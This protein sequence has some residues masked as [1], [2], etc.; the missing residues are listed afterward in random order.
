MDSLAPADSLAVF[1]IL[2]DVRAAE[3][4]DELD[5]ETVRFLTGNSPAGRIADLLDR[6]PMDD[7]AEVVSEADPRTAHKLLENLEARAPADAEEVRRLLAYPRGSAGRLMT[8]RFAAVSPSTTADQVLGYLR[9]QADSLETVNDIYVLDDQKFLRGVSAIRGVLT[10][11]PDQPISEFMITAPVSVT[12]EIHQQDAALLISRYDLLTLPVVDAAG[13][14]LGIV[15]IDDTVDVLVEEFNEDYLRSVGSD[16]E[17]LERK[18]PA[19]IARLRMPWI[20][21]TMFIEL[22]AGVVIHRFDRTLTRFILLASFMP[23][24]SAISGNTGLQSA[25]IIIRGLS[26]GQ[27]QLSGWRHAVLRQVETSM[28]L[29]GACALTLGLIGGVWDRHWVFGLVVFLGMFAS[30]NIAGVIGTV[31]PLLSKRAGFDPALTA[32][33]FETAFQD[34][35]GISIF[36]T[37]ATVLLQWLT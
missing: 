12:P 33:P 2:D 24:I 15:T 19:Q 16:A 22:L 25:A 29:G 37:L 4:L 28:I 31:V 18:T 10:A 17:E 8:D 6:L 27:V 20:L 11:R 26:S 5:P 3:V 23:I 13:H 7:A 35:I 34:V 32:G 9:Q 36:L 1:S 21:A 30:V 14:L